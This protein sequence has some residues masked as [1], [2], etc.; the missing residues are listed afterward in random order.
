MFI[1]LISEDFIFFQDWWFH[2]FLRQ[3]LKGWVMNPCAPFPHCSCISGTFTPALPMVLLCL[4]PILVAESCSAVSLPCREAVSCIR[5]SCLPFPES[6][7]ALL[8]SCGA[9]VTCPCNLTRYSRS[10]GGYPVHGGD[11]M[12]CNLMHCICLRF[13]LISVHLGNFNV[14]RIVEIFMLC[15]WRTAPYIEELVGLRFMLTI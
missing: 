11:L 15:F 7:W 1:N 13:F 12:Q 10:S 2:R 14:R 5:L 8:C 3:D 9:L 6:F 4:C